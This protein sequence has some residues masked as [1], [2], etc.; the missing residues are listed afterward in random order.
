[1]LKHVPSDP[2]PWDSS[3]SLLNSPP[4]WQADVMLTIETPTVNQLKNHSH[5]IDLLLDLQKPVNLC[6]LEDVFKLNSLE[7]RQPVT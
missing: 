1:M 2:Y 4:K 5:I 3:A 6:L 7:S